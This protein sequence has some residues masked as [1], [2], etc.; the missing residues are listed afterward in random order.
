GWLR[1]LSVG[2]TNHENS[3][4]LGGSRTYDNKGRYS[5]AKRGGE[6]AAI[7]YERGRGDIPK[8]NLKL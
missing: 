2:D 3:E 8:I 1:G 7:R 4:W 6:T 5:R